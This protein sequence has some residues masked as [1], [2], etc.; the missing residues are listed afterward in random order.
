MASGLAELG[1][2]LG[3]IVWQFATDQ[4]VRCRRLRGLPEAAAGQARRPAAAPRG[5]SAPSELHDA[6]VPGAGAPPRRGDGLRRFG[7]VPVVRRSERRLRLCP[8]DD[9]RVAMRDRIRRRRDPLLGRCRARTGPGASR[10]TGCRGSSSRR[11]RRRRA[12][13]SPSSSA[14]PRSAR[15]AAATAMLAELGFKP[16][17]RCRCSGKGKASRLPRQHARPA[18][19]S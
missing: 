3:P 19:W 18:R 13:C 6:R 17:R 8:A 7:R 10:S 12:T 16:T 4:G 14:A 15:R 2:K 5:R 1:P 9:D 11:P